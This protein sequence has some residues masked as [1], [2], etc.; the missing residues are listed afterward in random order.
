MNK[1][2][3]EFKLNQD[4]INNFINHMNQQLPIS[5]SDFLNETVHKLA[6]RARYY[7]NKINAT[8]D[9]K[10]INQLLNELTFNNI[11]HSVRIFPP[12]YFDCGI[13][14]KVDQNTFIN[15]CCHFQDQGGITIGK[16]CYI[17][18][19]CNFETLNHGIKPT[20]RDT[21]IPKPI[22]VEDNVWIGANVTILQG[23]TI[24]KNSIIAAGAVVIKDVPEN[25]IYGGVP[26]KLL[27]K[28][29]DYFK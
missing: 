17:G 18:P 9:E 24:H 10:Q 19:R 2:I 4:E 8:I 3:Q 22:V 20:Q 21:I 12:L 1:N 26:A 7:E 27:K 15:H 28:I 16:N 6:T 25:S 11:C 29:E 14:I 23:V 5:K 13:N